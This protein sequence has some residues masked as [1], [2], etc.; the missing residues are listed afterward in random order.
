MCVFVMGSA[1]GELCFSPGKQNSRFR[2]GL[3]K[4]TTAFQCLD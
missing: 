2:L 3:Y 4:T 1:F